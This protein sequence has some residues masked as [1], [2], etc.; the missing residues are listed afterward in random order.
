MI[1]PQHSVQP[2]PER[3]RRAGRPA[4]GVMCFHRAALTRASV[5]PGCITKPARW[6]KKHHVNSKRVSV[7]ASAKTG[8]Y[9]IVAAIGLAFLCRTATA[10]EGGSGH[11]LP[12]SMAS[13][14]DG[15]PLT[16]TFIARLN[17]VY[18]Q[19]SIGA[20]RPLPIGGRTALGASAS[21]WAYGLTLLCRPPLELGERWSYAMS[22]TIPALSMH[23]NADLATTLP[24]GAT[25]TVARA[26]NTNGL[27]D[28]VLMPLMLN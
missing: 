14:V 13:F 1:A 9:A 6:R 10:E 20:E 23:V 2:L 15:V 24:G 5:C 28:V 26:S 18:Y 22:A 19:G 12:G 25:G 3:R 11:Y 4:V 16:E 27:G 21:S 7:P 8:R 17:L